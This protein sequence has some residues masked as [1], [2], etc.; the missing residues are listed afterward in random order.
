MAIIVD[1]DTDVEGILVLIMIIGVVVYQDVGELSTKFNLS[2]RLPEQAGDNLILVKLE[3]VVPSFT[4]SYLLVKAGKDRG[5]IPSQQL[6]LLPSLTTSFVYHIANLSR[7]EWF[8][9]IHV[10]ED[11]GYVISTK[12]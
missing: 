10:F 11:F 12:V 2:R 7:L 1:D 5:D 4:I 3:L 9:G 8:V 6:Y